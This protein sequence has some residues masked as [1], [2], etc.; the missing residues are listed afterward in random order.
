M[1]IAYISRR[2]AFSA[3]HRL[4]SGSLTD[5]E[6]LEIFG[7]CNNP[8]GHGHNYEV[9]FEA[10][11]VSAPGRQMGAYKHLDA[12]F[13]L[14]RMQIDSTT[15]MVMNLTDL[16]HCIKSAVIDVMDHKNLDKDVAYFRDSQTPSTAENISVFIWRSLEKS[17]PSGQLHEVILHETKNNSVIYRGE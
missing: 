14:K 4:H 10:W 5:D 3:A 7:K 11:S 8:N 6:N 15:G 16:K 1:P 2:E 17:L 9:A 13:S 12:P